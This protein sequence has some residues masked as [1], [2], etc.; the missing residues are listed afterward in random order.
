MELRIHPEKLSCQL[1]GRTRGIFFVRGLADIMLM[2]LKPL[3]L[4]WKHE[5]HDRF[6]EAFI[7]SVQYSAV[8]I[9]VRQKK[10]LLATN[11]HQQLY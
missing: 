1:C 2:K 7:I 6:S 8:G 11:K 10:M 4:V 9:D 5:H 3:P